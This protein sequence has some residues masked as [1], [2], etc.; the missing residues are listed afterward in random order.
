[1]P[2]ASEGRGEGLCSV[3]PAH[4]PAFHPLRPEGPLR[5]TRPHG[6]ALAGLHTRAGAVGGQSQLW[7]VPRRV[8][9][10]MTLASDS[11]PFFQLL[12]ARPP[13]APQLPATRL[14]L[15][16]GGPEMDGAGQARGQTR[17]LWLRQF[18]G[19]KGWVLQPSGPHFSS[20][21]LGGSSLPY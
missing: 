14:P 1:M 15:P 2:S 10:T 18:W 7:A 16:V 11:S 21:H 4:D 9:P 20:R 6:A 12:L 19:R 5:R 3:G 13:S 17:C 8:L